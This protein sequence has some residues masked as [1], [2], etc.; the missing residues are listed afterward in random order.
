MKTHYLKIRD[1]FIENVATGV[2]RHEYRLGTEDRCQIQIGDILVLVSNQN[3]RRFVKVAVKNI[4]KFT[5]WEQA[6]KDN[7]EQDFQSLFSSFEDA[8]KECNKFY[9]RDEIHS[10]G[11]IAFEIEPITVDYRNACILLDTN[12]IIKR[13]SGNNV[14]FEVTN[15][16][17]WFDKENI[18]K[19][20][21]PLT[22]QELLK[23]Q[24]EQIRKAMLVKL[25]AYDELPILPCESDGYFESVVSKYPLNDN[26]K[27]DNALL[28]EVYVN[29]V[30]I[31]LT[32]DNLMLLKAEELY[33]RDKV[34]TSEELLKIFENYYPHHIEYKMLA[35]KLKNFAEI[36]LSDNF[37]NSLRD[38]YEGIKFDNWFKKK[39]LKKEK[40]YVFENNSGHLQ[41]FLYLKEESVDEDYSDITP[42]LPPKKRLKIG[43]FK[44]ESTGFRLGERFLK[45]IFDNALL[46]NVDEIYVTLFENKRQEVINLKN[47]MEL[48]GFEKHGY[49]NNGELVLTKTMQNYHND[50]NPKYNYPLTRFDKRYFFLPIYPQYHTDLFPDMIL[51][52]EDMHLY[53]DNF[54]HRYA[55]EKIY[56]T[57]AFDIKAKPGDLLLIYRN[58]ERIPKRYSSVVTGIAIVEEVIK[59]RTA[60]E[61]VALCKNRSIF[62]EP[63]IRR[64]HTK[65]PTIVRLLDFSSFK[66]KVTLGALYDNN[67]VSQDS[68]P[69][70]FTEI[71]ENQFNTIYQ[72]GME[73]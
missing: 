8:L 57:G 20:V 50:K 16:F 73:D 30:N 47:L 26:S 5:G 61:C 60:D 11:I 51:K 1:K 53:Q 54:P 65:Y 40:A 27:I 25:Q 44:I 7:W 71:T 49:K 4:R 38:D 22:K 19:F 12:I 31:L 64:L 63:D 45:I 33:I 70:P 48:W 67:I 10:Y 69:R 36:N 24:D 42:Q 52:N 68:G 13:E 43:T 6:L 23:H 37:F 18:T 32:D 35:V 46:F 72:L 39:A 3:R 62:S 59:T 14:S 41:G 55:V 15:L 34:L 21:H 2:K 66:N 9:T 28:N 17:R 58:G 56:L 29:N